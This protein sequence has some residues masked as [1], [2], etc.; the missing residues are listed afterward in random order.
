LKNPACAECHTLWQQY[1]R[2]TTDH[3]RLDSKLRLA[4]LSHEP[5]AVVVLTQQVEKAEEQ[6]EWAREA[7]RKHEVSHVEGAAAD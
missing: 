6:R 4:A 7:I 5:E 2:T 3:I 1:A